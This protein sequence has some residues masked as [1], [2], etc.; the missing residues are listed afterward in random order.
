MNGPPTGRRALVV[1]L[2]GDRACNILGQAI[3]VDGDQ[4]SLG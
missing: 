3:P 2:V 4:T 1:L